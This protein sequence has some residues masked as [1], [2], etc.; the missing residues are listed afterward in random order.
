MKGSPFQVEVHG[1]HMGS[2]NC[3]ALS[4]DGNILVTGSDDCSVR[5]WTTTTA[6][7]RCLAVLKGHE[8]YITCVS[9]EQNYV[10]S[11]SADK[12]I[13]KWEMSTG[14]LAVTTASH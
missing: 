6:D 14:K 12:T 5:I 1:E 2:V 8:K 10:V 11:G 13:R 7:T 9:L 4:G 3:M